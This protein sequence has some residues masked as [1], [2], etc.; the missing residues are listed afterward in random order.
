MIGGAGWM[1]AA[2]LTVQIAQFG[3]GLLLARLLTPGEFGLFA[4]VA[5]LTGFG[6]IVFEGGLR[7][8][9]VHLRDPSQEDYSTVFWVNALGGVLL[10]LIVWVSAPA[11]AE[12]Y[13]QPELVTLAPLI[14]LTFTFSLGVVHASLLQREFRF[15]QVA[16]IEGGATLSGLLA[17]L[18]LALAGAGVYALAI[19]PVFSQVV[20]STAFALARPWRPRHFVSIASLRR[21]FGYSLPLLG[22]N[23]ADYASKNVDNLLIGKFVGPTALGLYSRAFNLMLLPVTQLTTAVG[24]AVSPA[25]AAMR[26]DVARAT[27]A[28]R[29]ALGML[30]ALTVPTM[31]VL[32]ATA[33]GLVPFL[34]GDRWAAAAPLLA[35]LSLAG[36]PQCL[37]ATTA[38]LYQAQQRTDVMFRVSLCWTLIG[39]V[40][41]VI[42]LRWGATGVA[43]AVLARAWVG[44]PFE[45]RAATRRLDMR[46]ADFLVGDVLRVVVPAAALGV[47]VW[48]L[49]AVLGLDRTGGGALLLQLGAA[50][51]LFALL[52]LTVNRTVL[53][54]GVSLLRSRRTVA[55]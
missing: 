37:I 25:L 19:G 16:L 45:L 3:S 4:S 23:A 27:T 35:I 21:L 50:A 28:Y 43:W 15:R 24:G 22:A 51:V 40:G 18:V 14:A 47:A 6:F 11:I 13:G 48:L 2:R 54:N 38:W 29:R 44:L 5:V 49:P 39:C 53:K 1:A 20:V 17:T 42:G 41:I 8:A 31:A 26:D 52:S 34:W 33:D 36:I 55:A 12:F 7:S 46:F 10:A 30:S 32:A 9:L